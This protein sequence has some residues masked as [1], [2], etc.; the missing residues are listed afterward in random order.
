MAAQD[1]SKDVSLEKGVAVNAEHHELHEDDLDAVTGGVSNAG[2]AS[3]GAVCVS[4]D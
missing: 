3:V 2:A 4:T 1:P